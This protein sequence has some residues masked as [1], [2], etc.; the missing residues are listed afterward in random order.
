MDS[1]KDL[2]EK[3]GREIE[4]SPKVRTL[5]DAMHSLKEQLEKENGHGTDSELVL[6]RYFVREME[7]LRSQVKEKIPVNP[8]MFEKEIAQ[9]GNLMKT[10]FKEGSLETTVCKLGQVNKTMYRLLEQQNRCFVRENES[11]GFDNEVP[12]FG[13]KPSKNAKNAYVVSEGFEEK[14][15]FINMDLWFRRRYGR[16]WLI[17]EYT[18]GI[19]KLEEQ[20]GKFGAL[21]FIEKK[22]GPVG[23]IFMASSIIKALGDRTHTLIYR[24]RYEF[25]DDRLEGDLIVPNESV[26]IVYD[27]VYTGIGVMNARN[28]LMK[29]GAG[30]CAAVVLFKYETKDRNILDLNKMKYLEILKDYSKDQL[31]SIL[32]TDFEAPPEQLLKAIEKEMIR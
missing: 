10:F 6:G 29:K 15:V 22:E 31:K 2:F 3:E 9:I 20:V 18:N 32:K 26:C 25:E 19:K 5:N 16:E 11:Y 8:E 30:K 24:P 27:L 4:E 17:N 21:C 7:R 14:D 23:P 13:F 1:I 12:L 28:A